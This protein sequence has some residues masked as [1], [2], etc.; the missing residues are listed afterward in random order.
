MLDALQLVLPGRADDLAEILAPRAPAQLARDPSGGRNERGRVTGAPGAH[1][2]RDATSGDGRRRLDDLAHRV[3]IA[4]AAEVVHAARRAGR[5]AWAGST[6]WSVRASRP[7]RWAARP[8]RR[9]PPRSR[10]TRATPRPRP[11]S[12]RA[13]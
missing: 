9:I 6:A 2:R 4:T 10:R 13:T 7:P 5:P 12:H 1:A 11:A 3:A 8:A